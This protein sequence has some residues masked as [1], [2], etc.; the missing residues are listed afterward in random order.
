MEHAV[1]IGIGFKCDDGVVLATDTQYTGDRYK[2]NGPKLFPLLASPRFP[3]VSVLVAGAG[4]VPFMKM[5][6]DKIKTRLI[7]TDPSLTDFK[8]L[9]EDVLLRF[10]RDH[11]HPV[12]S[13][14]GEPP[15]FDLVLG[16]W[17]RRDGLGL[18]KTT[19]TTV[20]EVAEP[21]CYIG[22]GAGLAKYALDLTCEPTIMTV[23]STKFLASFCIKA[24]KDHDSW[25]GGETHISTLKK[26]GLRCLAQKVSKE[27]VTAAELCSDQLFEAL[28]YILAALSNKY[29][30]IG[31]L[32]DILRDRAI[33]YVKKF[34]TTPPAP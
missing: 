10:Y 1:T 27:E 17:T 22:S 12:P 7:N 6:I 26:D 19:Q 28:K 31:G 8:S 14:W 32:T 3:N 16:V 5:A 21:Y 15:S 2:S 34:Q 24:A 30:G 33:E 13:H 9:V 29:E 20:E 11:I 4:A 23:E 18:F 25:C